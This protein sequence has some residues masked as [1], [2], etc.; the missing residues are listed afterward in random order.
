MGVFLEYS[1]WTQNWTIPVPYRYLDFHLVATA[2]QHML[3]SITC[4][5]II[6][7][8]LVFFIRYECTLNTFV[9]CTDPQERTMN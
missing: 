4:I 5:H 6:T 3:V 9:L 8:D 2:T 1:D 7:I